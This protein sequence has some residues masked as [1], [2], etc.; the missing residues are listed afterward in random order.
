VKGWLEQCG[1]LSIDLSDQ[2][3]GVSLVQKNRLGFTK[4]VNLEA[5]IRFFEQPLATCDSKFFLLI[6]GMSDLVFY[7]FEF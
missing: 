6:L 4:D 7:P 2:V 5:M 3:E 1:P